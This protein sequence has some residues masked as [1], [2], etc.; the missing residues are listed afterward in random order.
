MDTRTAGV[1]RIGSAGNVSAIGQLLEQGGR[2]RLGAAVD[3]GELAD[4]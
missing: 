1:F 2:G 3:A 4:A